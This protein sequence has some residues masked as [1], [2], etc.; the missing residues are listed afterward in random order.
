M[1]KVRKDF[2]ESRSLPTSYTSCVYFMLYTHLMWP[3]KTRFLGDVKTKQKKKYKRLRDN[4]VYYRVHSK[5][6]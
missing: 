2:P 4:D 5:R 1:N 3:K 6:I